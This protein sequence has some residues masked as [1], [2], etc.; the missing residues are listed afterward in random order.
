MGATTTVTSTAVAT[1]TPIAASQD[2]ILEAEGRLASLQDH[3]KKNAGSF[4]IIFQKLR[5]Q[6][7][8]STQ[9]QRLEEQ[10]FKDV[11]DANNGISSVIC[12]MDGKFVAHG[13]PRLLD[14]SAS[15]WKDTHGNLLLPMFI[16]ALRN[17]ANG[18][19][20]VGWVTREAGIAG[21]PSIEKHYT[22]VLASS[23]WLLGSK[24]T[25]GRKFIALEVIG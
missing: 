3:F 10:D 4:E 15:N 22:A 25:S 8:Y 1:T 12:I 19:A 6:S 18:T 7:T 16:A 24:N 17:S 9:G 11:S 14:T 20:V 23:S 5:D 2:K 21:Q 13:D